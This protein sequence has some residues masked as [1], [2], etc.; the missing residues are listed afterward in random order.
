LQ[1]GKV[2]KE[3]GKS[4]SAEAQQPGSGKAG[5]SVSA[6]VRKQGTESGEVGK[7]ES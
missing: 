6:E 5:K 2:N 1:E 3:A 4:V 7:P